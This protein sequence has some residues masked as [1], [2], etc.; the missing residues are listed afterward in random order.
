MKATGSIR[1]YQETDAVDAFLAHFGVKG[2]H[3]GVERSRSAREGLSKSDIS[4][5]RGR[6]NGRVI[7]LHTHAIELSRATTVQEKQHHLN[8]IH[9]IANEADKSGDIE[10]ATTTNNPLAKA[11]F[12]AQK[13]NAQATIDAY[14]TS[15]LSDY[16]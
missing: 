16:Y 7:A 10:K 6:H 5:A 13:Q 8:E 4:E 9:K 14:K 11:H 2:M 12:A 3:W 15:K 1:E